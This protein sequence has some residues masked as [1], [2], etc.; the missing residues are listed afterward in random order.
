MDSGAVMCITL[1]IFLRAKTFPKTISA[2]VY[3]YAFKKYIIILY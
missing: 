1:D 2:S 3:L